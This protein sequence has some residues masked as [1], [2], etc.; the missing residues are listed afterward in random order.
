MRKFRKSELL[1]LK[2][3]ENTYDG[4]F[5]MD[6]ALALFEELADHPSI[7]YGFVNSGCWHRANIVCD[8]LQKAGFKPEKVWAGGQQTNDIMYMSPEDNIAFWS[9]HTAPVLKVET[10][11]GRIETLVFD[12]SMFDGPVHLQQWQEKMI[13][14][15]T[16][17]QR[18]MTA[19][20]ESVFSKEFRVEFADW[21]KQIDQAAER[22]PEYTANEFMALRGER[23]TVWESSIKKEFCEKAQRPRKEYGL[24]WQL[25]GSKI[26]PP[27][28]PP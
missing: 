15:I 1:P 2:A 21:K 10:E 5:D 14:N 12:P 16:F 22:L 4:V 9:Y 20:P 24:T 7:P 6:K 18:T 26:A 17:E 27:P 11:L 28:K 23:R 8:L 19:L 25:K 3:L 13:G